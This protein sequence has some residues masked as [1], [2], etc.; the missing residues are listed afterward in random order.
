[1]TTG[2][3]DW[4][5]TRLR[6][7]ERWPGLD[8]EDIEASQGDRTAL[9]ALLEGRLGYARPNAEEDLDEILEGEVIVP[10]DVADE[11]VHTGTS[12]P[13]SAASAA[14]SYT[15]GATHRAANGGRT[16]WPQQPPNESSTYTTAAQA[17]SAM[18]DESAMPEHMR[19]AGGPP[20]GGGGPWDRG[21][22]GAN[23]GHT[24]SGP[25]KIVIAILGLGAVLAIGM[26]IGRRKR[27][28]HSKAEHVTEQARHLLEEISERMP[29]VEELR[30]KVRS[31]DEARDKKVATARRR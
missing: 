9:I 11:R 21:H 14:P 28:Q 8:E 26:I 20:M 23:D 2:A 18:P 25:P 10:D 27:K 3:R 22:W 31:L 13:V 19:G 4:N 30:E 12:G 5:Q 1:M 24:R 29:S 6:I 16:E 17:Q 15:G 7:R